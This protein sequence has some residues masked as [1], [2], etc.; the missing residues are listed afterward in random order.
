MSPLTDLQWHALLPYVLPRSPA[1]RRIGDLRGRMD[2]I[3]HVALTPGDPWRSLPA[4]Y[5][6]AETVARYFRRLTHGGLWHGLLKALP[7]LAP[8]HPLRGIEAAILRATRRAARIG[9]MPLLLL[10]R[11]L[12]LRKALPAPPWL[13]PDPDLSETL[14]RL[15]P[16]VLA[17]GT[18]A[19]RAERLRWLA[20]L[21][22]AAAGRRR[23]P[24]SVRLAW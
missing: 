22:R 7:D 4:R 15:L 21:G 12:G 16:R 6:R 1:G 20:R 9:G 13:L 18:A 24:R 2:A 3:F 14:R 8:D 17:A 11:R 19:Q 5:G 10:I 23:I